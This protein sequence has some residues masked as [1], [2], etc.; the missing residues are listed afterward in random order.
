MGISSSNMR[1]F[2]IVVIYF[3]FKPY[4]KPLNPKPQIMGVA[5]RPAVIR[6]SRVEQICIG[7]ATDF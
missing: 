4:S 3:A 6:K 7:E 5:W 2:F 1:Y